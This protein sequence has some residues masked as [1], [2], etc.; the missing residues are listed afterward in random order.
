MKF[1][2]SWRILLAFSLTLFLFVGCANPTPTPPTPAPS[3]NDKP[4][5]NIAEY[6]PLKEGNKWSYEGIG[7][8]FASYTQEVTH[9]KDNKYQVVVYSGTVTANRYEVTEDSILHTYRE[10]EYYE[11]KSI[12][13][14]PNNLDAT[15]LKLPFEVDADWISEDNSYEIFSVNSTVQVPAGTFADCVV[16]KITYKDS[17]NSSFLYYKKGV[18]MVKSEY[19]LDEGES[20]QSL[21]KEYTI[22]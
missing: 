6:L 14:N 22:R 2:L 11:D 7:N 1:C 10:H 5:I 16:V 12:L 8:E 15:L 4:N 20:I 9:E 3:G 17:G 21:L 19:M 13:D 18:G